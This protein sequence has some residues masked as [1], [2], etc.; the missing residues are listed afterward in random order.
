LG[1]KTQYG[2]T[3][4]LSSFM[5]PVMLVLG[6]V[7]ATVLLE[8]IGGFVMDI[9]PT[10]IQD[11]QSDSMTGFFSILGFTALFFVLS[12]FLVNSSMS[13]TYLLPDAI[14]QF[15]GAH[16]SATAGIGRDGTT[17]MGAS[18]M[19]GAGIAKDGLKVTRQAQPMRK[20]SAENALA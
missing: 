15:I 20:P 14:F 9:Y 8:V 12:A 7:V 13:V 11:A 5:R 16:S 6:F 4:M 10:V 18:A 17:A 19:A 2:Y 3:F 1:H